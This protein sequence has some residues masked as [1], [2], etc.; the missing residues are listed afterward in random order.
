MIIAQQ[1]TQS[2][3]PTWQAFT[4]RIVLTLMLLILLAGPGVTAFN[5]ALSSTTATA[6]SSPAISYTVLP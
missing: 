3:Q 4:W 5:T 1:S 6:D 2:F